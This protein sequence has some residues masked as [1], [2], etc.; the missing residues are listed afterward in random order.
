MSQLCRRATVGGA[1]EIADNVRMGAF[2]QL[3]K[4]VDAYGHTV[5]ASYDTV[6]RVSSTTIG[7]RSKNPT[8]NAFGDLISVL[9]QS[10]RPPSRGCLGRTTKWFRRMHCN[11]TWDTAAHGNRSTRDFDSAMA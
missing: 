4:I 9:I 6:G 10:E 2:S 7:S 11:Y 5:Q 1:R 3:E 8:F